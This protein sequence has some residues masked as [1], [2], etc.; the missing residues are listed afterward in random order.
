MRGFS[1]RRF[2]LLSSGIRRKQDRIENVIVARVVLHNICIHEN[3]DDPPVIPELEA[4]IAALETPPAE[5]GKQRKP[6]HKSKKTA[7]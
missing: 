5:G 6:Q 3:A 7:V 4:A 2:P 1:K